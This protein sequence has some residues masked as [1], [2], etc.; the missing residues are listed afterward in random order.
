MSAGVDV[1]TAGSFRFGASKYLAGDG[2]DLAGAE[3]QE[4]EEV[5]GWVPFGPLEVH[6]G[7]DAGVVADV[8]QQRGQRVGHRGT[9]HGEHAE[10]VVQH[11]AVDLAT[12][13]EVGVVADS[14]FDEDDV[15]GVWQV[16]VVDDLVILSRYSSA[17]RASG[18][19]ATSLIERRAQSR[20]NDSARSS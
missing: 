18:S 17:S 5:H 15:A 20:R 3:E 8:E 19:L 12:A 13:L 16:V 6:V 9:G 4:P 2:G 11:L 7:A 14:D 1:R 10:L